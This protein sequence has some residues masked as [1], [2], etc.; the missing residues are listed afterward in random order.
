MAVDF[1]I[2]HRKPVEKIHQIFM[3]PMLDYALDSSVV[4]LCMDFARQPFRF[5]RDG[6]AQFLEDVVD[7]VQARVQ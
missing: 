4:E 7:I 6:L 3:Q 5:K 1:A 2:K